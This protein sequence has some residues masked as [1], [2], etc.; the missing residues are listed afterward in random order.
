MQEEGKNRR[1]VN[2]AVTD[3]SAL[4]DG[5]KAKV[6]VS[7]WDRAIE[8]LKGS[9][10]GSGVCLLGCTAAKS[11]DGGIKLNVW[12]SAFWVWGGERAQSLTGMAVEA[13]DSNFTTLTATFTPTLPIS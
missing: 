11:E 9:S 6:D 13:D 1:V 8:N 7:V 5:S 3:D 12:D 2:L 4:P 10:D